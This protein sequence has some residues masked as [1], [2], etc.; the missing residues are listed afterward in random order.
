M[1]YKI[2]I[3]IFMLFAS[4]FAVSGINFDGIIKKAKNMEARILVIILI[5]SLAYLS[6]S[7]IINFIEL[8]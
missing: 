8:T 7:F 6:S 4:V 3:Y 2:C 5:M 1:N